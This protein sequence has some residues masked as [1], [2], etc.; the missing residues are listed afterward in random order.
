MKCLAMAYLEPSRTCTMELLC[1]FFF[2]KSSI[3]DVRLG[4]KSA[5]T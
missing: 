1:E 5:F 2:A 4:S 3:V